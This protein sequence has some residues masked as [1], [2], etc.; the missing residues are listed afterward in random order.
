[1]I[2]DKRKVKSLQMFKKP[3]NSGIQGDRIALLFTQLETE[4]I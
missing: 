2:N 1:L 3:V 4:L